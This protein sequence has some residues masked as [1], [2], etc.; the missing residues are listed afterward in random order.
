M[1]KSNLLKLISLI[2][3]CAVLM[4]AVAIAAFATTEQE[5]VDICKKNIVFGEKIQ[6]MFAVKAPEDVVVTAVCGDQTVGI[7]YV[8]NQIIEGEE[9]RVYRTT[10]GWAA[11]NINAVVTVTA[12]AGEQ[13][14]VLS[15]SVLMYLYERLNLDNLDPV[16]DADRIAMYEALLAYAKA[17]DQVINS[18]DGRTPNDLDS[19]RYVSVVNGTVDGYNEWGMF[20]AGEKPFANIAHSLDLAEG[21]SVE[22][23]YSVDGENRGKISLA[24]LKELAVEGTV[25]VTATVR[26]ASGHV[27]HDACQPIA[28]VDQLNEAV[29]LGGSYYLTAD[30]ALSEAV[31]VNTDFTLCLGGKTLSAAQTETEFSMLRVGEGAVLTL[32][33]CS[34]VERVGYIDPT[35]GLWTEGTYEGDGEAV[36]YTL[37]GGVIM[38]GHAS[39][40]GAIYTNGGR[41]EIY[42]VNFAGNAASSDSGAIHLSNPA[43]LYLHDVSFVGNVAQN[44]GGAIE[45]GGATL[46]A[47]GDNVFAYNTAADHGGAL[48][49]SYKTVNEVRVGGT[50]TMTG[51]RFIGNTAMGGGAVSIRTDCTATF[52]GTQFEDNTTAGYSGE[53]DGDGECGGAIYVGYG[54]LNLTDCVLKDNTATDGFGGAVNVVGSTVNVTGGSFTG[55]TADKG[56]VIHNSGSSTILVNG[57]TFAGNTATDGG[58]LYGNKGTVTVTGATFTENTASTH[59]GAIY[60]NK[61]ALTFTD[62]TFTDNTAVNNGGAMYV[63]NSDAVGLDGCT[64]TENAATL[65]G[66]IYVNSSTFECVDSTFKQNS[67]SNHGGAID[68]VAT[69]ATLTGNNLFEANTA[70]NHGGAIYVTYTGEPAVGSTLE[71]TGGQFKQNRAIAGGAVSGR[72]HSVMSFNGV[73]FLENAATATSS[74]NPG[75]GAIHV[76][77]GELT[78]TG[79]TFDGNTSGYYG[80]AIT[81]DVSTVTLNGGT[82]VRNSRGKTGAALYFKGAGTVTMD[83]VTLENNGTGTNGVIYFNGGTNTLTGITATGNTADKGGVFYISGG[84]VTVSDSTFSGNTATA[85]GGVFRISGSSTKVTLNGCEITGNSAP[86]GG[87]LYAAKGVS[88]TIDES[89]V[90]AGNTPDD[91]YTAS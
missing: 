90:V 87:G 11:Q 6:L 67:A 40:G 54:E 63:I 70:T 60:A 55:N 36:S 10:A 66:A 18:Q 7:E 25:T 73:T 21:E 86:L 13:T 53:F 68:V 88:Y 80:G 48:H 52:N 69:E 3:V 75:G 17:A 27:D 24:A 44:Q 61:T 72:T 37:Y 19:Y 82:T 78:V 51:G 33:D 71:M 85:E 74:S 76:N 34:D 58:A 23:A 42:N 46:L 38:G 91:T 56:G 49:V 39:N 26:S 1:K 43:T 29:E 8:E 62:S 31:T 28:T 35:T 65:G 59:G 20:K 14:D 79:C 57:A 83:T 12:T 9:Y 5:T 4:G 32:T 22:W 89:T 84:T 30:L 2:S 77:S 15:Y 50:V 47:D 16:E 81:G 64:F 45:L 41:I